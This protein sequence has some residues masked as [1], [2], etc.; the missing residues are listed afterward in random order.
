M[1]QRGRGERKE[2]AELLKPVGGVRSHPC[3]SVCPQRNGGASERAS[4]PRYK[5]SAE[6]HD[7]RDVAGAA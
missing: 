2:K 4:E 1:S 3:L 5:K 6:R 7:E